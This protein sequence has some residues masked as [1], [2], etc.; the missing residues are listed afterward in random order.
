[1]KEMRKE[2]LFFFR[3]FGKAKVYGEND[4]N[5]I[6]DKND[7][8]DMNARNARNARHAR[9]MRKECLVFFSFWLLRGV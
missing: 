4:I 3:D 2:C 9:Y 7:M 8:N 6:N 1:M 5:D